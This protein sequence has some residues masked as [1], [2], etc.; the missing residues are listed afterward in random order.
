MGRFVGAGFIYLRH[1]LL[2]A[3][4]VGLIQICHYYITRNLPALAHVL[5]QTTQY[6]LMN[7]ALLSKENLMEWS[8]MILL[9]PIRNSNYDFS[10][11]AIRQKSKPQLSLNILDNVVDNLIVDVDF[12]NEAN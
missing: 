12:F 6:T 4:I 5:S 7:R 10:A 11:I 3:V 8:N 1:L 9:H 2:L